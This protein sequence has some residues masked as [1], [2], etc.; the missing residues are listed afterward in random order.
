M[1][2]QNFVL[3]ERN[4]PSV[5]PRLESEFEYETVEGNRPSVKPRLESEFEYETV[6]DGSSDPQDF[7]QLTGMVHRL[8]ESSGFNYHNP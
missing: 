6:E 2:L 7:Y 1:T 5:K 8:T 4:R 3:T